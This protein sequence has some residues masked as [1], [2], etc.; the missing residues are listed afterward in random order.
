MK[1][2]AAI[3]TPS[4][5]SFF[6]DLRPNP[7]DQFFRQA[8]VTCWMMM[9]RVGGRQVGEVRRII[10]EI[11]ERNMAAWAEDDATFMGG[12]RKKAKPANTKVKRKETPKKKAPAVKKDRAGSKTTK[13]GR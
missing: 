11:F 7:A 12:A 5:A 13:R 6:Q 9:P 4:P 8:M 1:V 10:G 2:W 3:K